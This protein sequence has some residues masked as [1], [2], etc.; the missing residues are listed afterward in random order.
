MSAIPDFEKVAI[1]SDNPRLVAEISSLFKRSNRY[2]PIL[3]APRIGRPDWTNEVG[4]CTNALAMAQSQRVI[5][6]DMRPDDIRCLCEKQ[7][8]EIFVPVASLKEAQAALKGWT[9]GPTENLQWGRDNL[10]IGL[11]LARLSK[12]ALET[13][14]RPSPTTSFVSNAAPLLIVCEAGHELAQVTASNLAFS[15]RAGLLIVPEVEEEE[16]RQWLEE[17]YSIPATHRSRPFVEIRDRV[18]S[19]LPSVEFATYKQVLFI[20][21]GFPWGIAVPECPTTHLFAY[22]DVGRSIVQGLWASHDPA[23]GARTALLIQPDQVPGAELDAVRESLRNNKT[24]VRRAAGHHA[25]VHNVRMLVETVPFDIIVVSTHAGD[26]PGRRITYEFTDSEGTSRRLVIDEAVGFGYD[27]ISEKVLV[28]QFNRFHRVDGVDWMDSEGKAKIN[29]GT[30]IKSWSAIGIRNQDKYQVAEEKIDRVI[31]SMGLRMHDGQV[32]L[33]MLQ[34]FPPR[35]SPLIFNNACS[36]W[37]ELSSRFTFAGARGYVGTLFPVNEMEAQ[38][39]GAALFRRHLGA[40]FSTGLWASQNEVYGNQDLRPY[41]MVGLPFCSIQR[42]LIDS[43][44]YLSAEYAKA[45]AD[46]GRKAKESEFPDVRENSQHIRDFLI[47]DE[48]AFA[49]F[50]RI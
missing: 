6:A 43:V 21:N 9:K 7:R 22:P 23:L 4:R 32:W 10:G 40:H 33:P 19:R 5:L 31:G 34:G 26:V 24:L 49:E 1:V 35:C 16:R 44:A 38:A 41:A 13:V 47:Q 29:A 45:I 42:N 20:T 27:P 15:L 3:E 8:R 50:W 25:T 39:V 30:A 48:K 2:L 11:L 36:S 14:D 28:Q 17:L 46:Y 18:R 12:K 37:H